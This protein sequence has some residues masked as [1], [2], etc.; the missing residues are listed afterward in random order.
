MRRH[1]RLR[2]PPETDCGIH[3]GAARCLHIGNRWLVEWPHGNAGGPVSEYVWDFPPT[4]DLPPRMF[5]EWGQWNELIDK[6][7]AEL[8][9]AHDSEEFARLLA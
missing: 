7:Y 4:T 2:R 1:Y 6:F 8:Q 3:P 9:P 5:I